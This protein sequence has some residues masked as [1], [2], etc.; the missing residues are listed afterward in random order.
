MGSLRGC[1]RSLNVGYTCSLSYPRQEQHKWHRRLA[2]TRSL[3][4]RI[5]RAR[6]PPVRRARRAAEAR[7]PV[8]RARRARQPVRRARRARQPAE[9]R[10]SAGWAIAALSG[11][12]LAGLAFGPIAGLSPPGRGCRSGRL[13]GVPT[14]SLGSRGRGA[15][16]IPWPQPCSGPSEQ[17]NRR[18]QLTQCVK[19]LPSTHVRWESGMSEATE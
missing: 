5:C 9:A 2:T 14:A 10:Q 17:P 8:R 12:R 11:R 16:A 7:P 3:A 18:L 1:P 6:C 13:R 19:K 4:C 15:G